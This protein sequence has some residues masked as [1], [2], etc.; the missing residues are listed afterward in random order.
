[1][2]ICDIGVVVCNIVE[3]SGVECR[4]AAAGGRAGADA[5]GG[6]PAVQHGPASCA[7]QRPSLSGLDTFFMPVEQWPQSCGTSLLNCWWT[8]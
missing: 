8:A 3:M 7:A 1:M 6:A 2:I 4:A 5:N